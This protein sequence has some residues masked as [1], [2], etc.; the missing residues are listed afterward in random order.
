MQ[1]KHQQRLWRDACIIV[2]SVGAA[3]VLGWSGVLHVLFSATEGSRVLGS[4]IAGF[5]FTSV[6]TTAPATVVL[7][8]IAQANSIFLVAFL[9]GA[10]A[11]IGDLVIFHFVRDYL[12]EDLS[13]L[14]RTSRKQWWS[15]I[16][17]VGSAR[18]LMTL[19]GAVIVASPLPDELGLILMGLSR[20]KTM[21]FIPLS[22]ALNASGILLLGLIA[23]TLL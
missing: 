3:V 16:L 10:G 5:F 22:F 23:R 13:Y 1:T 6:F 7:A 14:F 8:Q 19:L 11:V 4:F 15:A 21:Y 20:I 9:G 17:R 2:V 12:A 18:W